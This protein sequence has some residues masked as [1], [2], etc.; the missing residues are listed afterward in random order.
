MKN[1]PAFPA[2]RFI[3][4]VGDRYDV[5]YLTARPYTR[6]RYSLAPHRI[7]LQDL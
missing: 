3:K 4:D 6:T 2:T 1:D 5:L 7:G